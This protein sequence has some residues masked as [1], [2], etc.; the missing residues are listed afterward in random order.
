MKLTMKQRQEI[1]KRVEDA[2][3]GPWELR[4]NGCTASILMPDGRAIALLQQ[5]K[6]PH[7]AKNATLIA[8]AP[9][10]ILALL[11]ALDESERVLSNISQL[12]ICDCADG[13]KTKMR[14]MPS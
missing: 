9:T 13:D 4:I 2:W 6:K 7:V 3:E 1:R 10:D 5:V 12:G 11:D 8:N 14:C